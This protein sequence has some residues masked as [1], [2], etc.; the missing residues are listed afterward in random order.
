MKKLSIALAGAAIAAVALAPAAQAD[1]GTVATTV[2]NWSGTDCITVISANLL[3]PT[4]VVPSV[5][6][7]G[8]WTFSEGN[9]WSGDAFGADP[10]MGNADW[11]SCAVIRSGVVV[12]SDAAAAGDG[13]DVSCLRQAY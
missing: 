1:P 8:S 9:I 5:I 4:T 13:T 6:C 7:G 3:A 2:I 11:I 10:I 12:Y